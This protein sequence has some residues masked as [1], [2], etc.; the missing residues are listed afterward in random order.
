MKWLFYFSYTVMDK[1]GTRILLGDQAQGTLHLLQLTL[2]EK[3]SN[4]VERLKFSSL[5]KVNKL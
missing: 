4:T 5:G 3:E 2:S 1:E